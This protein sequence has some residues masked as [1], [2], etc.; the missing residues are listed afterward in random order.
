[1][2]ELLCEK[3]TKSSQVNLPDPTRRS[4]SIGTY[5]RFQTLHVR[6]CGLLSN[7]FDRVFSFYACLLSN[8]RF[9]GNWCL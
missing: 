9:I 6:R 1:M 2:R 3:F 8:T 4:T 5:L 7:Y